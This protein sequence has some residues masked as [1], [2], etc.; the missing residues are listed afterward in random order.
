MADTPDT[1]NYRERGYTEAEVEILLSIREL[2]GQVKLL[3]ENSE[4]YVSKLEFEPIQRIVY[5][6]VAIILVAVLGAL[7]ALV[8]MK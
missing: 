2:Q 7:V 5:G 3:R 8:V 6:M 4:K 1:K